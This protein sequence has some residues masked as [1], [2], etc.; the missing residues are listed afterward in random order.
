MTNKSGAVWNPST[1]R[2]IRGTN[3]V[4]NKIWWCIV[5]FRFWMFVDIWL[6]FDDTR[7]SSTPKI[8]LLL[9]FSI[10]YKM[11]MYNNCR[12]I[13][14]SDYHISHFTKQRQCTVVNVV[15]CRIILFNFY[16]SVVLFNNIRKRWM[17]FIMEKFRFQNEK[18]EIFRHRKLRWFGGRIDF[19]FSSCQFKSDWAKSE[20]HSIEIDRIETNPDRTRK[21]WEGSPFGR[22]K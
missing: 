7:L 13:L 18:T 15:K 16:T 8:T 14:D 20:C 4:P 12:A 17:L 3:F 6:N 9:T 19:K 1:S 2:F 10:L 11:R 5:V 21:D 22:I